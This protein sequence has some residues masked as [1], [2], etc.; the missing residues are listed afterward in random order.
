MTIQV[1]NVLA[2]YEVPLAVGLFERVLAQVTEIFELFQRATYRLSAVEILSS[3]LP[4]LS[5]PS[6]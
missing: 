3:V 6:W 5:L 1:R 4:E 2:T